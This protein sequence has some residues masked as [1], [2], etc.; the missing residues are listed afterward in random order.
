VKKKYFVAAACLALVAGVVSAQDL[1]KEQRR[2]HQSGVVMQEVLN[3]PDSIPHDL[4]EKA[5]CVIVFPSLMKAAFVFG[6]EYGCGAMVCRTGAQFRGP[7]GAPAMYALEGGSFGFQIGA[8]ATDLI[9]LVMNDRGMESI[10]S[11]KVKLGGDASVAAGPKGRDASADTDAWM[12]AEL[13]SYS[14]SRGFFAGV[15]VEGTTLRPD[16]EANEQIYGHAIKAKEIVRSE[17]M[18]VPATGRH[19]VDVLEKSAPRNESKEA[20]SVK[21]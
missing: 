5:E 17:H 12:R 4:L 19:F 1:N 16:D 7:W 3:I 21:Q 14:R 20:A 10:L 18:V 15:S 2:L 8:E 9:L 6:A 11:S 13:L